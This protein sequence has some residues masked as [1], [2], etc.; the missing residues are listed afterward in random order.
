MTT[1]DLLRTLY[2]TVSHD[3]FIMTYRRIA[4][5]GPAFPIAVIDALLDYT[6]DDDLDDEVRDLFNPSSL[7]MRSI[8]RK[9][10]TIITLMGGDQ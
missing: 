1:N 5:V 4:A 2:D 8:E 6:L 10:D 7:P 3:G 9:L